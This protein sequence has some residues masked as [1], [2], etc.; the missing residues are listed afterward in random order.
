M[1]WQYRFLTP[2]GRACVAKTLLLSKLSH[3]AFVI[4]SVNK[5]KL[6]LIENEIYQF[7][8]KGAD[9]VA[10]TAAKQSE[11]R[12]GLNFP[13]IVSSWKAFKFSWF[14]RLRNNDSSWKHIFAYNLLNNF[15]LDLDTFQNKLGTLE[16]D[17]I[18]KSFP[19]TFWVQCLHLIKP[20]L[21][22]HLKMH[23]DNILTYPIWGSSVFMR[24]TL[25]CKRAQFGSIG[26]NITYPLEITK[27]NNNEIQFLTS[28]EYEGKFGENPDP[29]C[30]TSLKQVIRMSIQ[31]LGLRLES[32]QSL[33]PF[34][35]PLVRLINYSVKG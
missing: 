33:L 22:E 16:Y 15:N 19:N 24:N 23:P 6:K 21:L 20:F 32:I 11:S 13:D 7:I 3:L 10:R 30:Y 28:E 25:E 2:L 34:Q 29:V 9:K 18:S 8:W 26:D 31:K 5:H 35:P 27:F 4:P 1:N 14:R 12:G 17:R